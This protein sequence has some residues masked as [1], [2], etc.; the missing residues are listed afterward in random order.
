MKAPWTE[1]KCITKTNAKR[2]LTRIHRETR[3]TFYVEFRKRHTKKLRRMY[4]QYHVKRGVTGKGMAF[5]PKFL[6]LRVV[7][8]LKKREHRMLS[9][10]GLVKIIWRGVRYMVAA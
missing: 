6:N 4:A 1:S 7:Y 10:E 9:I 8:D 3:E 2:L 5:D